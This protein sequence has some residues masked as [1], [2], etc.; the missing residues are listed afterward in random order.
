MNREELFENYQK[1]N[2]NKLAFVNIGNLVIFSIILAPFFLQTMDASTSVINFFTKVSTFFAYGIVIFVAYMIY[3]LTK[4]YKD[5]NL[6]KQHIQQSVIINT[7][8][9]TKSQII[10]DFFIG[11]LFSVTLYTMNFPVLSFIYLICEILFVN[12]KLNN[13]SR[14]IE[15][16]KDILQNK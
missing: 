4:V 15:T 10:I 16:L 8:L 6:F 13:Y 5:D 12:I 1:A 2:Q 7:P 9:H 3:H 11:I 14:S